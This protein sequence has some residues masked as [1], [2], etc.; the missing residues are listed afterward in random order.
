MTKKIGK[1]EKPVYGEDLLQREDELAEIEKRRDEIE[2][3][4][5]IL[6]SR[7]KA[8][9]EEI[10]KAATEAGW[11]VISAREHVQASL[12]S[13]ESYRQLKKARALEERE[14]E[15]AK[16]PPK[17]TLRDKL[18]EV[19]DRRQKKKKPRAGITDGN[20]GPGDGR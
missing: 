14:R 16:A 4:K 2:K 9:L 13:S 7:R 12:V 8:Q 15:L 18:R 6:P 19:I 17:R 5:L 10:N 1:I 11:R 20:S 3:K